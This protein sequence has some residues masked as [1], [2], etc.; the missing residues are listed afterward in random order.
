MFEEYEKEKKIQNKSVE[1]FFQIS[2]IL[3]YFASF[4]ISCFFMLN[5]GS[6]IYFVIDAIKVNI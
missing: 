4:I 6:I 3:D 1:R 5:S 2:E